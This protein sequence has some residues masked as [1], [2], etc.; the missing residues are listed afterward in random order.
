[1][2]LGQ[3]RAKSIP[4][5][6]ALSVTGL[7]VAYHARMIISHKHTHRHI[8]TLHTHTHKYN[9]LYECHM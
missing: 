4:H 3:M 7:T 2:D 6:L 9:M 8:Q 5:H 1:M